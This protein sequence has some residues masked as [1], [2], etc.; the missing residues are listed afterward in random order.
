MSQGFIFGQPVLRGPLASEIVRKNLDAIGSLNAGTTA[1]ANPDKIIGMPWLDT[2]GAPT[3]F[4]L[5]FFDGTTFQ[6]LIEFPFATGVAGVIRSS[7]N[8]A[9]TVWT[10]IHN[11]NKSS[12]AVSLYDLTGNKIDA[13]DVDVSNPNQAVVTHPAPVAGNALII[14]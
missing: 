14:G 12:V 7:I 11:L 2:T 9:A 6:T 10:L 1:P 5:K 3:L 4:C 13:S 8:P